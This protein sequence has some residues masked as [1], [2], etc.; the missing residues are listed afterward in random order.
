MHGILD[1]TVF[2]AVV[3][4]LPAVVLATAG[5]VLLWAYAARPVAD[6][7]LLT[8]R[9]LPTFEQAAATRPL[10]APVQDAQPHSGSPPALLRISQLSVTADIVPV[11]TTAEGSMAVPADVGTVGWYR[12]SPPPGSARGSMVLAGHVNARGQG[13]GALARL[14]TLRPGMTIV[15]RSVD[16]ADHVYEV[17]RTTEYHK[18]ALPVSS[19]FDRNGQ[20]LLTLITCGGEYLGR[21]VGYEDNVVV[22]AAPLRN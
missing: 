14:S 13:A 3:R 9:R 7:D 19:I 5:F 17:L 21:G 11:P 12:N 8:G 22:T 10:P 15:V 2:Q 20:P 6:S 18:Q 4:R 16:G 1:A